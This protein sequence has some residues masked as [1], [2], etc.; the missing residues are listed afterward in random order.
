MNGQK[1]LIECHCMLPQYRNQKNAPYHKFVTFSIIDDADS[2]VPKHAACNNCGVVHNVY[3][4]SKSE[5]L[6][7]QE[8]GAVMAIS[9][10][11]LMLPESLSNV[12]SSYD[13]DIPTWEHVLF[14]VQNNKYPTK[15]IL[16]RETEGNITS[17]K[18]LQ[19]DSIGKY[20]IEPYSMS[21]A[22]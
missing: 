14:T 13:C 2:V 19:M 22:V 5:I 17:G 8:T 20:R 11:Q 16:N 12:L 1:H 18:V 10:I 7:G 6:L 21:M 3:D 9:D 4:I 15:I